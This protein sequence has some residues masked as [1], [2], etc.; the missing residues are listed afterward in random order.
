MALVLKYSGVFTGDC[1]NLV[2]TD[3]TG[4]YSSINQTG[5]GTPN[6]ERSDILVTA[7][8][9]TLPNG[10]Q[11]QVPP[12]W[13]PGPLTLPTTQ[14]TVTIINC[15]TLGYSSGLPEGIYTI[16]ITE[17]TQ[18]ADYQTTLSVLN[19]CT[20]QCCLDKTLSELELEDCHCDSKKLD[21]L[22]KMYYYL[23]AAQNAANCNQFNKASQLLKVVQ[24]LCKQKKCNC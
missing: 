9:I 19:T 3:I 4:D 15:S 24:F 11:V 21:V 18:G 14:P 6:P 5:Y 12:L 13:S 1:Q 23:L 7:L 10:T 2:L 8:L 20:S 17:S 16:L 22:N